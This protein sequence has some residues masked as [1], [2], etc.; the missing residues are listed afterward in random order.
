MRYTE[1]TGII[2]TW[3]RSSARWSNYNMA[4]IWRT[5]APLSKEKEAVT[6]V[7]RSLASG[8]GR[9]SKSLMNPAHL[10]F[11][12]TIF[13]FLRQAG[14]K[15]HQI[16]YFS[17][18]KGQLTLMRTWET[19]ELRMHT[20]DSAQGREYDFV[21]LDLVTSGGRLYPLGFVAD[22][23]RMCVALSRA[24]DRIRTEETTRAER[25]SWGPPP[26]CKEFRR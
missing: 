17:Y 21:I 20:V 25:S 2:L 15:D 19:P 1:M 16:A 23:K 10:T 22:T 12:P 11:V 26:S 9:Q 7:G 6:W 24:R 3:S 18:Y 4:T 8:R 5:H 13:N 14:A